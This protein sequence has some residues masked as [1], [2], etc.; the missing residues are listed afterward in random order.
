MLTEAKY[1]FQIAELLT[2]MARFKA[3][4]PTRSLRSLSAF[5]A[6]NCSP[7]SAFDFRL[8]QRFC[9]SAADSSGKRLPLSMQSSASS[10]RDRASRAEL[11]LK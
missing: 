4:L 3:S 2:L 6:T 10:Q 11:A 9:L 7:A 8:A 5:S 1:L